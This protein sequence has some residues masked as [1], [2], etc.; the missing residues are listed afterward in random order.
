MIAS[1]STLS[2]LVYIQLGPK[3]NISKTLEFDDQTVA[4]VDEQGGLVAIELMKPSRLTLKRIAKKFQR[5]ELSRINLE[6][7]QK[8]FD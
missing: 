4:E 1:F 7:L 6:S 2:G 8:A 5:W 3:R